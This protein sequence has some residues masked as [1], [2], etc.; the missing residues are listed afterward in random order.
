M[1]QEKKDPA[2]LSRHW[3]T[4][5]AHASLAEAIQ[6]EMDDYLEE[7]DEIVIEH[8][9]DIDHP[10]LEERQTVITILLA[11]YIEAVINLYCAF[12]F[13]DPEQLRLID[14]MS[15]IDKWV[16]VPSFRVPSYAFDKS[17]PLYQD[18]QSLVKCRNALVHMRPQFSLGDEL[19][20][21][22]NVGH[23]EKISH[24]S[25]MRW[26][27]L[28][29]KLVDQIE[30]HD[31]SDAGDSLSSVSHAWIVSRDWNERLTFFTKKRER[32]ASKGLARPKHSLLP[33]KT[34]DEDGH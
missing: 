32:R 18:L 26:A 30:L 25:V 3:A 16:V 22:G 23:L 33:P 14:K 19:I 20:H 9:G 7:Y 1:D 28:P 31:K 34:A 2:N 5:I 29:L 27:V 12:A 10:R 8:R 13:N 15:L 11:S 6:R 17:G 4:T 24:E 21:E